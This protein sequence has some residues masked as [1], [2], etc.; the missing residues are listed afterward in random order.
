M[1][2]EYCKKTFCNKYKLKTHQSTAK[3]CLKIQNKKA[4]EKYICKYCDKKFNLKVSYERHIMSHEKNED[5]MKYQDELEKLRE[6]NR[7]LESIINLKDNTIEERNKI[8]ENKE[9]EISEYKSII[10]RITIKISEN[11]D[12]KIQHLT[13]KYVKSQPRV[14]YQEINVIYI[15]FHTQEGTP[16]GLYV[17]SNR[18]YL[19]GY[20]LVMSGL[21]GIR[22]SS[23]QGFG[24]NPHATLY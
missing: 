14:K 20:G 12:L 8:I 5:F 11:K 17:M 24:V 22:P 7:N 4:E 21:Y 16:L 18:M 3:Y 10:E 9:A 15:L 6:I 1:N 19:K 13:K 2:C 23:S